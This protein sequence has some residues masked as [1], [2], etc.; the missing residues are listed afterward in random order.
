VLAHQAA[1]AAIL[2]PFAFVMH[3]FLQNSLA[4]RLQLSLI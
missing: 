2:R 3:R 4:A 1:G